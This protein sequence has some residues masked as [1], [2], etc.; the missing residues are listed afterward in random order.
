[1][2]VHPQPLTPL[3]RE[4][5]SSGAGPW[6]DLG[7]GNMGKQRGELEKSL[8]NFVVPYSFPKHVP[9]SPSCRDDLSRISLLKNK[10]NK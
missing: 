5:A 10:M 9:H 2:P 7:A 3:I 1:M 4:G 8:D 6:Q